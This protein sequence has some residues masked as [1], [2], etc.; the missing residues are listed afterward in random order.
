M[1]RRAT[2]TEGDMRVEE[3]LSGCGGYVLRHTLIHV[4]KRRDFVCC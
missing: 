2:P 3:N 1:K 4:V